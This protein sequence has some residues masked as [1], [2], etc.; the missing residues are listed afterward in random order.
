MTW[1]MEILNIY[2]KK[3]Q[4]LV[5]DKTFKSATNK[6]KYDGHQRGLASMVYKFLDKKSTTLANKSAAA[7]A[8]KSATQT[9]TGSNSNFKYQ[10]LTE[11]EVCNYA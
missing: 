2:L 11:T 9:G 8:N 6:K 10:Q 5:C 4:L 7:S 3:Q 1:F